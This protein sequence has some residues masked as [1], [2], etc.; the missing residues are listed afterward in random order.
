VFGGDRVYWLGERYQGLLLD[1]L[2]PGRDG[3]SRHS[4]YFHYGDCSR[5]HSRDCAPEFQLQEVSVCSRSGQSTLAVLDQ[6]EYG[7]RG[8]AWA[9]RGLL[10][11]D[12]GQY[13]LAAVIGATHVRLFPGVGGAAGREFATRALLALRPVG[14]RPGRLPSPALPATLL[15]RLE[16][17]DEAY[18]SSGSVGGAAAA[19]GIPAGQVRRRLELWRAIQAL[20]RVRSVDCQR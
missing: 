19:I 4:Y 20:P 6:D 13:D 5:Y 15:S 16:R 8:R 2:R 9:H 7:G 17:T 11:V 18:A 10:F 3:R 12:I 1:N 14:G